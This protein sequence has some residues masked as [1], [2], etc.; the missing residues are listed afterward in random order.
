MTADASGPPDGTDDGT[1]ERFEVRLVRAIARTLD[2]DPLD[3]P[4]LAREVDVE[5]LSALAGNGRTVVSFEYEG[6]DVEVGPGGA[7]SVAPPDE[8][9]SGDGAAPPAEDADAA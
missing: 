7:V 8:A 9:R 2:R 6:C 3:L 5:A 4:P 1:G